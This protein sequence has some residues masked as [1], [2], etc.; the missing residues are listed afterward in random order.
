M[1]NR[2][3]YIYL[4]LFLIILQASPVEGQF[5]GFKKSR[6]QTPISV[7]IFDLKAGIERFNHSST[8]RA[9]GISSSRLATVYTLDFAKFNFTR[10]FWK[11][12]MF[13]LQTGFSISYLYALE[14]PSLPADPGL[15]TE[16]KGTPAFSPKVVEYNLNETLNFSIGSRLL[17]YGQISYGYAKA[18][19]YRSKEGSTYLSGTS[20][21]LGFALGTQILLASEQSSRIG[22]GFE[23]KFTD[24]RITTLDDPQ[25][26]ADISEIDLSHFGLTVTLGM[27]FGGKKTAGDVAE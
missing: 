12:S 6:Y 17:L 8:E 10:Y 5:F 18:D 24:L 25:D 15:A 27:L 14:F 2:K 16:F 13:D 22:L 3:H 9:L 4:T 7:T 1:M 19:L 21:P 11:Q 20:N 26:V 23:F